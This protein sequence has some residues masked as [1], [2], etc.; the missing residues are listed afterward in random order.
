MHRVDHDIRHFW[1]LC[2][3]LFGIPFVAQCPDL[4]FM[5]KIRS[6]IAIMEIIVLLSLFKSRIR[7]TVCI[8]K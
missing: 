1:R 7:V 4:R 5:H 8:G 2:N 3:V 6:G